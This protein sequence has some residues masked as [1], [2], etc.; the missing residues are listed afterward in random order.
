MIKTPNKKTYFSYFKLSLIL[1]IVFSFT[2]VITAEDMK[3]SHEK[4]IKPYIVKIY[5][6]Y[7]SYNSFYPWEKKRFN[8]QSAF[9]TVLDKNYI[10]TTADT[11]SDSTYIELKKN[12]DETKYPAH[13]VFVDY[14]SNIVLLKADDENFYN[15]LSSLPLGKGIKKSDSIELV[16]IQKNN[17]IKSIKGTLEKVSVEDSFIGWDKHLSYHL[18]IK[19]DQR[20][21]WA[22]PVIKDGFLEGIL[23]SYDANRFIAKV[24]PVELIKHFL[25]DISDGKYDGFP[26]SGFYWEPLKNPLSKEC[27]GMY[28]NTT[29]VHV[30]RVVPG[31]SAD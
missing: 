28:K 21:H 26:D 27:V 29:G 4:K 3:K 23:T 11:I 30:A 19:L 7:Q 16:Q 14:S 12:S 25:H 31:S 6:T 2:S 10:L 20:E 24:I 17:S 5:A 8:E 15:D 18:S 1:I 22:D 9:G 13:I